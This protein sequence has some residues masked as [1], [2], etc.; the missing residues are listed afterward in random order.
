MNPVQIGTF[1]IPEVF[2]CPPPGE[3]LDF[4][5]GFFTAHN[6]IVRG[7]LV[8]VSW[9]TGGILVIDISDPTNPRQVA[10]FTHEVESTGTF[11]H[12][13]IPEDVPQFWGVYVDRDLV[14]GSDINAGIFVL[15]LRG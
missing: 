8:F 5:K 10:R 14:V 1:A 6:P 15:K 9:Y 2:D 11:S 12:P 7:N 13:F 3:E 4:S